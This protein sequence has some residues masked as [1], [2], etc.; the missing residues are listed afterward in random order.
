MK[1]RQRCPVWSDDL[2]PGYASGRW[3]AEARYAAAPR[4]ANEPQNGFLRGAIS[5]GLLA[6]I[7]P[8]VGRREALRRALQGGAALAAGIAGADAIDRRDY[9]SALLA[10]AAGAAGLCAIDQLFSNSPSHQD[11]STNEQEKT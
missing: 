11:D 7:A 2:P 5:A 1:R 4:P 10:L 6:A 8:E 9:G 3:P